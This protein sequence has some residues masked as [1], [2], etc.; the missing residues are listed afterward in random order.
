MPILLYNADLVSVQSILL[1]DRM[2]VPMS[3]TQ[4]DKEQGPT[5]KQKQANEKAL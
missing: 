2:Q 4:A 3:S 1:D 5:D